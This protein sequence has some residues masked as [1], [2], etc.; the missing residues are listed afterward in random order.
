MGR[1]MFFLLR[2]AFWLGVVCLLAAWLLAP[3]A[4]YF[5]VVDE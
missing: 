4:I 1:V 3:I 2:M 5:A